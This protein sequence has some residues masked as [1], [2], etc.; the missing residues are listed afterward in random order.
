MRLALV[1]TNILVYRYDF[2]FPD[3]QKKATEFLRQGLVEET[4]RIPHQ[5]ILEFVASA[6]RPQMGGP[7]LSA[8]E[9]CREAEELVSQFEVI[10]PNEAVLRMALRGAAAFQLPWFDADLWAYAESFGLR[11]LISE[12][13]E[14]GRVYGTVEIVNP[15][16]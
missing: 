7:L 4:I 11:Q 8:E 16:R 3:K 12:D 1:D 10:Y 2:R 6:T 14:H 9:A 5:A 13:F 15:F